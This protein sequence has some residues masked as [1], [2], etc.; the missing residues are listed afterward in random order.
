M[1]KYLLLGRGK[2]T[3]VLVALSLLSSLQARLAAQETQASEKGQGKN[4]CVIVIDSPNGSQEVKFFGL[5]GEE[6]VLD[7]LSEKSALVQQPR[8]YAVWY[9]S[10]SSVPPQVWPVNWAAVLKDPTEKSNYHVRAGDR[11]Y[12]GKPPIATELHYISCSR[13]S[14]LLDALRSV[15]GK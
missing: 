8:K 13:F 14:G 11:T 5:S 6:S 7:L 15:F 9:L 1:R 12:V 2:A 10:N 4:Q 3:T